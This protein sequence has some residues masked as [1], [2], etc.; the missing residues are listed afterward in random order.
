ML[1]GL[2]VLQGSPCTDQLQAF[3]H[4]ALCSTTVTTATNSDCAAPPVADLI[5]EP[6]SAAHQVGVGVLAPITAPDTPTG[7]IGL[8]LALLVAVLL[9]MTGLGRPAVL[10]AT[11]VRAG[12]R[13]ATAQ[14]RCHAPG[15]AMLCVSRT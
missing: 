3:G 11:P 9:A 7:V 10:Q 2:T 5:G 1:I 13:L 15:L 6:D 4:D 8:C 14:Q 12:P